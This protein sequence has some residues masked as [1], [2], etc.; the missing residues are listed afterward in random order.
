V[1]A[2]GARREDDARRAILASDDE[3]GMLVVVVAVCGGGRPSGQVAAC[4]ASAGRLGAGAGWLARAFGRH[5]ATFVDSPLRRPAAHLASRPC[6]LRPS[7]VSMSAFIRARTAT[8]SF[9]T[10]TPA[11]PALG[12]KDCVRPKAPSPRRAPSSGYQ[13]LTGAPILV[14]LG[15]LLSGASRRL[16]PSCFGRLRR[17]GPSCP[18]ARS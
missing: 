4:S 13:L 6:L 9:A 15:M 11:A 18:G 12:Q 16:T 3:D 14:D 8:R 2:G 1:A 5:A 10:A 17:S 7:S